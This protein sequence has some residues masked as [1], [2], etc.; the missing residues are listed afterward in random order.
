MRNYSYVHSYLRIEVPELIQTI[1]LKRLSCLATLH[2]QMRTDTA[3]QLNLCEQITKFM[4]K[5]DSKWCSRTQLEQ[6]L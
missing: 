4:S 6:H 1:C 3:G 2:I 5:T